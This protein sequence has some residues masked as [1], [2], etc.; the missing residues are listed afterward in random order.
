MYVSVPKASHAGNFVLIKT[1]V[2]A[3]K[4]Q[5]LAGDTGTF[6]LTVALSKDHG[7]YLLGYRLGATVHSRGYH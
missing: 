6:Q 3:I 2:E 5:V 4:S 1:K 7:N